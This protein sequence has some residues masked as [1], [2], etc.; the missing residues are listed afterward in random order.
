LLAFYDFPAEHQS[1]LR[2]SNPI[3]STFATVRLRTYRTKRPGSRQP[4]LALAFKARG[5]WRELNASQKL[6]NLIDDLV[7]VGGSKRSSHFSASP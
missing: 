5:R 2:T 4:G 6:Q 3:E 1:H 7:F